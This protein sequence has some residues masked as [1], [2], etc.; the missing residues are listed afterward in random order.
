LPGFVF[1]ERPR[2]RIHRGHDW[3]RRG[4]P[5]GRAGERD[6]PDPDEYLKVSASSVHP[7]NGLLSFRFMEPMEETVYLD[8]VR[9]LAIDHS[10]SYEVYP[11][12]RFVSA[13][14]FPEFRV[15]ASRGARAPAGA[16][17]DHGNDVLALI[18]ERDRKYVTNLEG[19]PFAGFRHAALAR[20][21]PRRMGLRET[22]A[23]DH[24]W[25]YRLLHGDL[26]VRRR[27]SR[28]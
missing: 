26:D 25:L 28:N 13:P 22:A 10:A 8:Q 17:D 9:L 12:E 2:I 14:P 4:R 5:L 16:W 27:S 24:R 21:G 3:P 7:R 1:L 19:L 20:A 6:V 11:N 18:A 15:I 23:P